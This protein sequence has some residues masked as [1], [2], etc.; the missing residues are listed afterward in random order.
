MPQFKRKEKGVRE[1]QHLRVGRRL[2]FK[3]SF[4]GSS[5]LTQATPAYDNGPM[6]T[7][8]HTVGHSHCTRTIKSFMVTN[9]AGDPFQI[10]ECSSGAGSMN[11]QGSG[12]RPF[13]GTILCTVQTIIPMC[14]GRNTYA[15]IQMTYLRLPSGC[16]WS[17]S[18][19]NP[20]LETWDKDLKKS[21]F[22]CHLANKEKAGSCSPLTQEETEAN[23]KP[24]EVTESY[25]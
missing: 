5:S 17:E 4:K 7:G 24:L 9:V 12:K 20:S 16:E 13:W 14:S 18:V 25:L 22:C 3:Y 1:K 11:T 6:L 8:F 19:M 15:S 21:S 2:P 23:N 10:E